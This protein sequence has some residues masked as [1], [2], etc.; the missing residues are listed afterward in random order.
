MFDGNSGKMMY[1]LY[2]P[3][4]S[5]IISVRFGPSNDG[6]KQ[7]FNLPSLTKNDQKCVQSS[8]ALLPIPHLLLMLMP[9]S[10]QLNEFNSMGDTLASVMGE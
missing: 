2:D 5:G 1:Q 9:L 10:L 3:E 6:R 8:R 4:S 7:G